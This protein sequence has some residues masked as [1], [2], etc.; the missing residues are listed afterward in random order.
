MTISPVWYL[1]LALLV[2]AGYGSWQGR[3][4]RASVASQAVVIEQQAAAIKAAESARKRAERA[5]VLLRQKNAVAARE[6]ALAGKAAEA[7]MAQHP[8]WRD[9]PVPKEIQDA[10]RR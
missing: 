1:V 9:Q 3:D 8:A 10:L 4:L 7:A 2:W 5:L 6:R